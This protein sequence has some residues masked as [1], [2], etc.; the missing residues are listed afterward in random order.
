MGFY[1]L[2]LEFTNLGA[3]VS[4]V[5][6]N[7]TF[8]NIS[9]ILL[10]VFFQSK[11]FIAWEKQLLV[12]PV[13]TTKQRLGDLCHHLKRWGYNDKVI[14]SGF[15]KVSEIDRNDLLEYKEK[16]INKPV[17][18]V[19]TYHPSIEK[20]SGIVRHHWKEI[21]KS[22]TMTK[23]FPEPPIVAFQRPKSIKDILVIAAV[24]RPSSTVGQCK[25][26][27]DKCCKCC[28]Q[29]QHA[30]VFHSKTTGK[31]YKIFCNV[32]C[33]TPNVV[34]LLDCHVCGAQ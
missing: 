22:E 25:P 10:Q 34:Y 7:A 16:K 29:L 1:K 20:I 11:S 8:N 26:C 28:L 30:Q 23:L 17:P 3:R 19:L 27:G 24:S 33:K 21:Q 12:Y 32:N 18:L 15:S 5:L 6:L 4:V 9:V 13:E 14:E 2:T 31:E